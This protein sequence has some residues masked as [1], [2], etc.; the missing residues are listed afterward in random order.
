[1]L[2]G[3]AYRCQAQI[4]MANEVDG[5]VGGNTLNMSHALQT[6]TNRLILLAVAADVGTDTT[7]R[8]NSS[9]PDVVTYGGTAMLPGSPVIQQAG[10]D[11][12]W[13]PDHF[14]YYLVESGIG[15][16]TGT[17]A[18]V[19]NGATAPSPS[20]IIANLLQ[21]NGVRQAT[22]ISAFNGGFLG[23]TGTPEAID[24]SVISPAVSVATTGSRIYSFI[25]ALWMNGMACPVNATTGGCP[26]WGVTPSANLTQTE[27][28][29]SA[30]VSGGGTIMRAFGSYVS[31][32]SAFFP[33]SGTYTPS[34]TVP[35]TGR[36]THLA[37]VIHPAQQ[38]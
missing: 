27:T 18:V 11:N 17:Q 2:T 1:V 15:A 6:G 7:P 34:W 22:P 32:G 38:P 14:V 26:A 19:I 33:T 31:A 5:T 9:R 30:E 28:L 3:S 23:T 12:Y 25:S 13:G 8:I 29:A 37:V 24:P 10:V 21:L 36:M 35:Y 20:I 16:K 4:T